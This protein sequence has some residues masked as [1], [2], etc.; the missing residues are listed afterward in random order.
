MGGNTTAEI[1]GF[2]WR[3]MRDLSRVGGGA[4]AGAEADP[5]TGGEGGLHQGAGR[6][7]SPG[8]DAVDQD[9]GLS[10]DPEVFG[11]ESPDP[12]LSRDL[13]VR[14]AINHV[15]EANQ[16]NGQ[17]PN[18]ETDPRAKRK[19]GTGPEPNLN[20]RRRKSTNLSPEADLVHN[21]TFIKKTDHD[22]SDNLKTD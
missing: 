22:I 16:R 11:R 13:E 6:G 10:H 20:Q 9:P 2:K 14:T 12:A 8:E 17:H 7:A 15:P 19:Q 18:Q 4:G 3:N 21:C 5:V 1:S